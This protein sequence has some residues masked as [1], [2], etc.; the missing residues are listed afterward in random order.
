MEEFDGTI[1]IDLG[2]T[3]SCVAV[4]RSDAVE[5]IPNDQGNRTTPSCVAFRNGDVLV[6]DS[7][8]QLASRGVTGVVYDA[9]R[10]IGRKFGE[11][12]IHDDVKR[13]PFAVE[14][15]ENDGVLIRVEHNG[16]TL[17]L[18]PEQISARVLAYLKL[19]AEQF[20]GKRVKKAVITVPAY[21]N[22]AQRERT[23]AAA[24]IAGLEVLRIVNE[25]TAAA[26]C[27]GL[28][29]GSGAGA[30]G[31]DCP[32]NVL[33]FD[34]GGGTFDVSIIAIDNGSFAVRSTAGDTH[35]GGQD[36]DTELL[37]YVLN[38]LKNRHGVDAT[39]QPRLLAKLLARCEQAKRVLSHA[40]TE[41]IVMDGI[42]TG[43]EEYALSLSR[44]KLEELCANIFAR[45][46]TVVQKAM[47]DAAVTPDEIDDVILVGGSSRIPALRVML[48]EMFKGKRL[49]SSVHPDEAVAIGAAVQAS[50]ISTS[51]EQQSEKTAN[52]VLMDVVPLS[53]GVEVDDGKF[54]VIIRRNT[55]I[56]YC[57]TKEYSTVED[58][59]E[60]VEVQVFEGERPL[61]RHN[62]KL[63]AFILDGI[64]RAKKGDPTITVT[65]SVD[66]DGILT[67]TASEE[68]ANVKKTLIVENT[69]R[70]SDEAVQKMIEVAQNFSAKDAV[71]VSI[72][73]A[74]QRLTNGFT[75]LETALAAMPLPL[76]K[77]LQ[78]HVAFLTH[79]KQWLEQQL[80]NYTETHAVDV[81][82]TKIMKLVQKALKTLQRESRKGTEN[83]N[84][85][86]SGSD[87]DDDT[88]ENDG[89]ALG[90]SGGSTPRDSSAGRKRPRSNPRN[91][92]GL[93]K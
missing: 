4:F 93:A 43:G 89:D 64:S 19:C 25:P 61:T 33:V 44:A 85:S 5:V 31:A 91:D 2:T 78:R 3:Y 54:D 29:L 16:E 48:Q 80:P 79:G 1:G 71:A 51:A 76:S 72:M 87:D 32:V 18:E 37:R 92:E 39:S 83:N 75:E 46:M 7:A 28:G 60:E 90:G 69:E 24:R 26:L 8:K 62:H 40:T 42:L 6:G 22:D 36:V 55:T 70:L 88:N 47:K 68:L 67:I 74:T 77:K 56:P 15:G 9:K 13:W 65:F 17:R 81:K 34:F 84:E 20:I 12:T 38:D 53:I 57:A 21:F 27:Y 58:N 35:L 73:D 49:C 41:E 10:M 86:D 59:Q 23:R 50:I 66:A 63:G 14:K 82:T 45:C 52:V 30:Q 11:K